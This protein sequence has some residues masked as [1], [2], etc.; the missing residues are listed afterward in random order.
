MVRRYANQFESVMS[1]YQLGRNAVKDWQN[2][3]IDAEAGQAFKD[4]SQINTQTDSDFGQVYPNAVYGGEMA[5]GAM[6]NAEAASYGVL[7]PKSVVR[8]YGLGKSPETW[9]EKAATPQEQNV[10]GMRAMGAVYSGAGQHEKALKY[11]SASD[12]AEANQLQHGR[13]RKEWDKQDSLDTADSE[14]AKLFATRLGMNSGIKPQSTPVA[15]D[16]PPTLEQQAQQVAPGMTPAP[17]QSAPMLQDRLQKRQLPQT[18][19]EMLAFGASTPGVMNDPKTLEQIVGIYAKAGRGQE[20]MKWAQAVD[21]AHKENIFPALV[22]LSKGDAASARERFNA[23]GKIKLADGEDAL[24]PLD[25]KAGTWRAKLAD[26]TT[27]DFNPDA[28]LMSLLSPKDY[29]AMTEKQADNKRA[30]KTADAQAKYY[31]SKSKESD[32]NADFIRGAKSQATLA[33][34]GGSGLQQEKWDEKRVQQHVKESDA[35]LVPNMMGEMKPDGVVK[36]TYTSLLRNRGPESAD[37][38]AASMRI[39]AERRATDPKT[40]NIDEAKSAK[41]YRDAW[42]RLAAK[43]AQPAK[44]APAA[45]GAAQPAGG[46]P[47]PPA[48][49]PSLIKEPV[50]TETL[51]AGSP[52]A[53][54]ENLRVD[55]IRADRN[56]KRQAEQDAADEEARAK[57]K[58][59]VAQ[60]EKEATAVNSL[61]KR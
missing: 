15:Q 21:A 61:Y 19:R 9:T 30:D 4:A 39:E 42:K 8:R 31:E 22:A 41:E 57:R 59:K 2:D 25:P 34:G 1:G 33:K 53:A 13:L 6:T 3:Q 32:A 24:T 54:A 47:T 48:A 28:M 18:P 17:Q 10:A 38:L 5:D 7:Q 12:A 37:N 60:A 23:G 29:F 46:K 58:L 40:G 20:A 14:V 44:V 50:K 55:K 35:Y 45:P 16:A 56:A 27:K 11:N 36:S 49:A 52:E 43:L 26:G 51:K